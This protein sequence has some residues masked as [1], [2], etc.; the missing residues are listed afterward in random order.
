VR[1]IYNVS[2]ATNNKGKNKMWTE[3]AIK[4]NL[5][6]LQIERLEDHLGH[7][8][9]AALRGI[10]VADKVRTTITR[11]TILEEILDDLI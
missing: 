2:S 3:K 6:S 10:N 8:N 9:D 1:Y 5:I 7:L 11:I 4:M